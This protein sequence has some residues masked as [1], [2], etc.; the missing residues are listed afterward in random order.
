MLDV[1]SSD[2]YRRLVALTGLDPATAR[3]V[4]IKTLEMP[5]HG[6]GLY[7]RVGQ[8]IEIPGYGTARYLAER[9]G[10]EPLAELPDGVRLTGYW[11]VP[12]HEPHLA[13]APRTAAEYWRRVDALE[14]AVGE[15]DGRLRLCPQVENGWLPV[16]ETLTLAVVTV[17]RADDRVALSTKSKFGTLRV[18]V[19]FSPPREQGAAGQYISDVADWAEAATEGRCQLS[20]LPGWT[21]PLTPGPGGWLY[22]VSD[23]IRS[24]FSASAIRRFILPRRPEGDG[25]G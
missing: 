7:I 4:E 3:E 16:I 6:P 11:Q 9:L 12:L 5:A 25:N 23:E 19:S 10:D 1:R 15:L 18:S 20:G 8:I 2:E 14:S 21:G 13:E 17:M 22:T 24:T